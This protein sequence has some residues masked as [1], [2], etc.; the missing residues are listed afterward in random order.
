MRRTRQPDRIILNEGDRLVCRDRSDEFRNFFG[1][2]Q[3]SI[4]LAGRALDRFQ[5]TQVG[6]E[7]E[8]FV[9]FAKN[10]NIYF[11]SRNRLETAVDGSVG[12]DGRELLA[13]QDLIAIILQT[14]AVHL[15]LDFTGLIK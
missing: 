5:I 13:E 2:E 7:F 8:L 15:S 10:G 6:E 4:V 1:R 3:G 14:F 9:E 12:F 11:L